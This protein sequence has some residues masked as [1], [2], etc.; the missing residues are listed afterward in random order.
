VRFRIRKNAATAIGVFESREKFSIGQSLHGQKFER[1]VMR[2]IKNRA[3]S[4]P[5]RLLALNL[6]AGNCHRY[7]VQQ[8]RYGAQYGAAPLDPLS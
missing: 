8:D 2:L 4:G 7:G 5:C 3:I 6:G 1:L